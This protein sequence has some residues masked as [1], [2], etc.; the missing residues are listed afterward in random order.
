[1]KIKAGI[2]GAT[3]YAGAE[4]VRL[5]STH[6][7]AEISAISSVSFEGERL[8]DVYPSYKFLNDM[9]CENQDAVVE[10]S[11]V[12]FAALPHGLSQELAEK[13]IS[14]GK[15]F[16]DLGADFR[17]ESE[18]E[19]TEW[20]GGTF[21]DKK[22]H[23]QSVAMA[24]ASFQ[25]FAAELILPLLS[26]QE[27][28]ILRRGRNASGATVPRSSNPRDYRL[29]TALE[30]LF[31]FLFLTGNETRAAEL[32]EVIYNEKQNRQT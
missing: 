30:A 12:I 32:F 24:R 3:G 22:L 21:L 26:E 19:Y 13:C 14:A 25:A 1:M 17:L 15:A 4:L 23:E 8:S 7:N 10:K 18:D 16:I 20:Y 9:V 28:D 11:D 31:G 2:V 29:A 5:L 6:P 27:A